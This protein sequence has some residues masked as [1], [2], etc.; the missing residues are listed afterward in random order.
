MKI[1]IIGYSGSGKSTTATQLGKLFDIPVLHLD[2]VQFTAGWQE[3]NR[4]EALGTVASFMEQA[5]WIIDG[6]YTDFLQAERLQAA[7]KIIFMDFPRLTCLKRVLQRYL[8]YRGKT[9]PDMAADCNEKI[10]KDFLKW[11]LLDGRSY[12]RKLHY[13]SILA[14]YPEKSVILHNQK[15]LTAFLKKQKSECY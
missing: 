8:Q 13:R 12:Q 1:A 11:I 4:Q 3:S 10:D 9:R 2:S 14:Q 6:N 15:E 5:N 7:D